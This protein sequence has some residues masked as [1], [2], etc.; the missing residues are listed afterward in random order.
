MLRRHKGG[1]V[2]D[3]A[4]G[5]GLVAWLMLLQDRGGTTATCVDRTIPPSAG[6]IHAAF[7]ARWPHLASR[8]SYVEGDVTA[9][10]VT[11]AHRVLGVHACGRLT[12][13]VLDVALEHRARVAV[14]P[15]CHAHDTL[16]DGGLSGWMETDVAIDATRAARLRAAGYQVN[17]TTIPAD[18][19]PK[20]RLL[21]GTPLP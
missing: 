2:V 13:V 16:D 1:P 11:P 5:H 9:F 18:I 6:R 14:L 12:D 19:S 7:G 15:C 21:I 20:N 17:T 8:V 4:G 3:L 10:P